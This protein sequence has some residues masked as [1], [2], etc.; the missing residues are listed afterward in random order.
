[1]HKISVEETKSYNIIFKA[2]S[3]FGGVQIFKIIIEI[4]KQKIIAVLLGPS[5]VGVT[6][7][8]TSSTSLIQA[9]TSMG[10]SSSAVK[11]VAEANACRD[12]DKVSQIIGIIKKLV[13]FTG[14]L[15]M[16]TTIC[17]APLVSKLT[18]GTYEYTLSF[19]FL[20]LTLLIQQISI[21]QSIILQGLRKI[22]FLAKSNILGSIFGLLF[23]IPF[24]YIYKINGI[25]PALIINSFSI[26]LFTYYFS[27]KIAIK[28]VRFSFIDSLKNGKPILKMGI[29]ISLNSILVLGVAY[30]VRLYIMSIDGVETVGLYTAGFAII[31]GYIGLILNSMSTDYYPRLA[32]LNNDF[33]KFTKIVNQQAEVALLLIGP[34]II[35][36]LLVAPYAI[37]LLYSSDFIH[38]TKYM[39]W[40]MIG[41]I[42]KCSAWAISFQIIAKGDMRVFAVNETISNLY[43]LLLNIIGYKYGGLE[44][45]GIAFLISYLLY[46][47]QVYYLTKKIYGFYLSKQ[48][49]KVKCKSILLIALSFLLLYYNKNIMTY[50]LVS[51]LLI[52]SIVFSLNELN[53]RIQLKMLF[54]LNN[55]HINS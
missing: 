52:G 21:G 29:V 35:L 23:S 24:Y 20:S 51:V 6:G 53:K 31:N 32:E 36:F 38:I 1:M 27:K 2:T 4:L 26:F 54:R 34:I 17:L 25:V 44:G 41:M 8:F 11:N 15:G 46:F 19:I 7:L 3:I 47:F 37:I 50:I 55:T 10:L 28:K 49:I 18:F 22:K 48:L 9:L 43:I 30:V 16:S 45:I 42:F 14:I 39:Q 13:L 33:S 12:Q 5:G 40:G